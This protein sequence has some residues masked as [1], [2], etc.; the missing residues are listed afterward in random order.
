ME[1]NFTVEA[2]HLRLV[3]KFCLHFAFK[4]SCHPG[5]ITGTVLETGQ[6]LVFAGALRRIS[7]Q[8]CNLKSVI[9]F[10]S[11]RVFAI[12][13][14]DITITVL[15]LVLNLAPAATNLVSSLLY[16]PP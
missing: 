8:V 2:S 4:N 7:P 6:F 14:R 16:S 10:S 1:L 12:W 9:V 5:L 15:V 3:I 11:L 13:D